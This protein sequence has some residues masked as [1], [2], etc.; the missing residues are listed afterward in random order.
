MLAFANARMDV[1]GQETRFGT[2]PPTDVLP[3]SGVIRTK[4][5]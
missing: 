2:E 3:G 4:R 5:R 1:E